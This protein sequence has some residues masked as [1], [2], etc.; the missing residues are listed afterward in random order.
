[1]DAAGVIGRIKGQ[2]SLLTRHQLVVDNARKRLEVSFSV[3]VGMCLPAL[4]EGIIVFNDTFNWK[5]NPTKIRVGFNLEQTKVGFGTRLIDN[6]GNEPDEELS[7]NHNELYDNTLRPVIN[8]A[9]VHAG[10]P[11][12]FGGIDF[13]SDYY[14]K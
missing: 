6:W 8:Q 12:V 7:F 4:Q 14:L 2:K 1:M 13:P 11:L 5:I 9:L 3:L 10:I